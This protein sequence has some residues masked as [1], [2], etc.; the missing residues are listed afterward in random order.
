MGK[1]SMKSRSFTL[2]DLS[3]IRSYA[4]STYMYTYA[5]TSSFLH[6]F[7]VF[8]FHVLRILWV[9]FSDGRSWLS[10]IMSILNEKKTSIHTRMADG[11]VMS[12]MY[13]VKRE[14]EREREGTISR[15]HERERWRSKSKTY[16]KCQ[17]Q[18]RKNRKAR[19]KEEEQKPN[20][21][22]SNEKKR[23]KKKN[24]NYICRTGLKRTE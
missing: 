5:L 22:M 8:E 1:A 14:R 2:S 10:D 16:Y 3:I 12:F 13:R 6:A 7:G 15:A 19:K 4:Y 18:K 9:R 11:Y 24:R 23:T 17:N 20:E 21:D